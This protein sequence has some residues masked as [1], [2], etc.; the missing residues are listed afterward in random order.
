MQIHASF[1]IN[2]DFIKQY[3]KSEKIIE[4]TDGTLLPVTRKF[5]R[6]LIQFKTPTIR[7]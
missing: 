2:R 6:H 4:L 5:Q 3:L 1:C 7:T